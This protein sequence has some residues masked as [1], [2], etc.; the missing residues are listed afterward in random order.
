MSALE[1]FKNSYSVLILTILL[2]VIFVT[3]TQ[4]RKKSEY[5]KGIVLA[6]MTSLLIITINNVDSIKPEEI[7]TGIA[8]F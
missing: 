3:L 2:A 1:L 5:I 6:V 8:P 4:E 7:L